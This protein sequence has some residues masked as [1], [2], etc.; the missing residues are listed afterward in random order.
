[1]PN[2]RV[3]G[4]VRLGDASLCEKATTMNDT[5]T[6]EAPPTSVAATRQTEPGVVAAISSS[7]GNPDLPTEF[8][9]GGAGIGYGTIIAGVAAGLAIG[10]ALIWL[11]SRRGNIT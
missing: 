9:S 8:D 1:M 6:T 7:E 11:F 5:M 10:S 4:G 2:D 3:A